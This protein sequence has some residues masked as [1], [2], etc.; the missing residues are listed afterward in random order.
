MHSTQN[1][2]SYEHELR[3]QASIIKKTVGLMKGRATY[4]SFEKFL[5]HLSAIDQAATKIADQIDGGLFS[6]TTERYK[7]ILVP[8]DGSKHSKKALKEAL[9]IAR[10]FGSQ[11]YLVSVAEASEVRAP[12]TLLGVMQSKKMKKLSSKLLEA[13]IRKTDLMLQKEM[14]VCRNKGIDAYYHVL[15]GNIAN[16]ILNFAKK[17]QIDL[18]VIGSR[19]L[20]GI[21]KI[22][23]LGSVSRKVSEEADCPVMIMH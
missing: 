9:E 15:T 4:G 17:Y 16:S 7:K 3:N 10:K 21:S 6:P 5:E 19:G 2:S 13:V 8:Y 14:E 18:I 23:S 11:A 1:R 20:S 12:G 22:M